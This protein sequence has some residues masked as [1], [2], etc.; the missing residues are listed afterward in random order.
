GATG[1]G[2]TIEGWINPNQFNGTAMP[3]VEWDSPTVDGLSL[4]VEASLQLFGNLKDTSGMG[5]SISSANG[6]ISTNS[7]QHVAMT[8]DKGSGLAVLYING[9][10]VASQNLG[11]FITPQTTY[12]VNIGIRTGQPI[13]NGDTYGGLM[14]ELSL[15]NRALSASE[16]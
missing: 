9:V 4:W 12:P 2:I 14:D 8:Y 5:H 1:S 16:I 11:S 10:S 15:Y 13:G 3:I 7:F 6:L